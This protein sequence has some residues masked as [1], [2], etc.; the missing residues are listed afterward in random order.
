MKK[1]LEVIWECKEKG[2]LVDY[3]FPLGALNP[4]ECSAYQDGKCLGARGLKEVI[5]PC[6]A[7]KGNINWEI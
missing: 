6:K 7:K 4:S 5:G 2:L 3:H 1:K